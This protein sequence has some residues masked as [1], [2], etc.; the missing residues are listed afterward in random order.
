MYA[1]QSA[2][3]FTTH[4]EQ[5]HVITDPVGEI[6]RFEIDDSS[7]S[8]DLSA[9]VQITDGEGEEKAVLKLA[10]VLLHDELYQ[11]YPF[12]VEIN[13]AHNNEQTIAAAFDKQSGT[14]TVNATTTNF[15]EFQKILLNEIQNIIF[16]FEV[17]IAAELA[18]NASNEFTSDEQE[19][20]E[21]VA[22]DDVSIDPQ[23]ETEPDFYNQL[24][25]Q[26]N[27]AHGGQPPAEELSV[28]ESPSSYLGFSANPSFLQATALAD[29]PSS[30]PEYLDSVFSVDALP[31][32]V[33]RAMITAHLAGY[34]AP[35]ISPSTPAPEPFVDEAFIDHAIESGSQT[36]DVIDPSIVANNFRYEPVAEGSQFTEQDG[37][38]PE[39]PLLISPDVAAPQGLTPEQQQALALSLL[40]EQQRNVTLAAGLQN[41]R[42]APLSNGPAQADGTTSFVNSAAQITAGIMAGVG[43]GLGTI[44]S[45]FQGIPG[46]IEEGF[47][48]HRGVRGGVDPSTQ[49]PRHEDDS[50]SS[51]VQTTIDQSSSSQA[52]EEETKKVSTYATKVFTNAIDFNKKADSLFEQDS[53]GNYTNPSLQSV[54]EAETIL[55]QAK[56]HYGDSQDSEAVAGIEQA[57]ENLK[58]AKESLKENPAYIAVE[59]AAKQFLGSTADP[60]LNAKMAKSITD[61]PDLPEDVMHKMKT[62]LEESNKNISKLGKVSENIEE[63]AKRIA[64]FVEALVSS[65]KSI[66]ERRNLISG[67]NSS[68]SANQTNTSPALEV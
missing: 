31:N 67:P 36:D 35:D 18:K 13:I 57:T 50:I 1:G 2:T 60:E 19:S 16:D 29:S 14:M 48:T 39:D 56:E 47:S 33:E 46:A 5:G 62:I 53:L 7:S 10:E 54:K 63:M 26:I 32:D 55:Q 44:A 27:D 51:A 15:S 64:E 40:S 52:A 65:I 42:S 58:E 66:F 4:L 8:I 17:E 59:E 30:S 68:R 24:V 37:T 23:V 38:A 21:P 41:E 3:Q 6:E 12:L 45:A 43:R 9:I 34:D 61:Q 11:N 20:I 28:R 22:T 25:S 49:I